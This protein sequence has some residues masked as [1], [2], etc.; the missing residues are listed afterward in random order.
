M[1]IA[2]PDCSLLIDGLDRM[3]SN[4]LDRHPNLLFR[5][6]AV[7]M[8]LQIDTV[9]TMSTV[10]QWARSLQAELEIL[11]VSGTDQD[12]KTPRVAAVQG[13][14][15]DG[16]WGQAPKAAAR[17]LDSQSKDICRQWGT[18][19]GC[20]RGKNCQFAHTP[21]KPGRC[22]VCGGSH[23]KAEC[24]AL[25]GAKGPPPEPRH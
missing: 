25:G 21:E 23:Q 17:R 13:K 1:S 8:Q 16:N 5:M 19:A 24:S 12:P 7:R 14:G 6:H 18:E 11:A 15:K 3:S 2:V 10:E 20:K 4:L 22:W 9:P